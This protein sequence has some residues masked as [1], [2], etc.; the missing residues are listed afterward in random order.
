MNP[1][2]WLADVE[3][4][5]NVL[6]EME[7]KSRGMPGNVQNFF[8]EQTVINDTLCSQVP[9]LASARCSPCLSFSL[10]LSLSVS[11]S[12]SSG[13]SLSLSFPRDCWCPNNYTSVSSCWN[14]QNMVARWIWK[15]GKL[16]NQHGV[17]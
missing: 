12:L 13:L 5:D 6:S 17:P 15:S 16:K 10:L 7:T 11:L 14:T 3:L 9:M 1:S 4:V 8:D 2:S